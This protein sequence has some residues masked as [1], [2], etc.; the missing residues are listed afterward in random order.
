MSENNIQSSASIDPSD[1]FAEPFSNEAFERLP[2]AL[3]EEYKAL[4]AKARELN[5]KY[6][7]AKG[8]EAKRVY[9]RHYNKILDEIYAFEQIHP[10]RIKLTDLRDEIFIDSNGRRYIV[11]A[12]M[13][14]QIKIE[15]ERRLKNE[16][17]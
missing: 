12:E 6:H 15:M 16:K 13:Q 8:L 11:S 4:N 9:E 10:L 14:E 5:N 1:R 17:V 7:L 2:S 3:Q